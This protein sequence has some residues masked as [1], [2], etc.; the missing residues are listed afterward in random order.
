MTWRRPLDDF[1]AGRGLDAARSRCALPVGLGESGDWRRPQ[2]PPKNFR[3]VIQLKPDDWPVYAKLAELMATSRRPG[4]SC[5][6]RNSTHPGDC[7]APGD[8]GA[9]MAPSIVEWKLGRP[10]GRVRSAAS[11]RRWRRFRNG[12]LGWVA[13]A[14]MKVAAGDP[15]AAEALLHRGRGRQR[16]DDHLPGGVYSA[17][18]RFPEAEATLARA[19]GREPRNAAAL[20]DLASLQAAQNRMSEAAAT[21]R[22]LSSLPDR[23]YHPL[24]GLFLLRTGKPD[25][26]IAELNGN[27]ARTLPT[28]C[29]VPAGDRVSCGGPRVRCQA[30]TCFGGTREKPRF[31]CPVSES[32]PRSG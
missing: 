25:L 9:V 28:M 22:A 21:F 4:D 15:A 8:A 29:C 3:E 11:N 13:L 6:K 7:P 2:S 32:C 5:R 31:R 20:L 14:N 18:G 19:L 23:R 26:A 30:V 10:R 1:S 24:Y 27:G 16:P 17:M 12:R